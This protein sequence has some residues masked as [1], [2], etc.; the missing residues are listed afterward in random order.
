MPNTWDKKEVKTASLFATLLTLSGPA[1]AENQKVVW[2]DVAPGLIKHVE[3]H[4][5][6]EVKDGCWTNVSLVRSKVRLL[7]EQN[8]IRLVDDMS[9]SSLAHPRVN[10]SANGF[11]NGGFCAARISF[12]VEMVSYQYLEEYSGQE[13]FVFHTGTIWTKSTVASG[14]DKLNDVIDEFFEASAN[15][16]VADVLSARRD[17]VV[18]E[19]FEAFPILAEKPQTKAEEEAEQAKG[20]N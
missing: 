6:D 3:V 17:P 4:V 7:L 19:F 10:I 14:S 15:A 20:G 5:D 13:W 8:D 9:R 1:T 11:R 2:F 12:D 18:Q 16:F